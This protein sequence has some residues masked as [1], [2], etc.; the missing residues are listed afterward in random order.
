VLELVHRVAGVEVE[1]APAGPSTADFD[2]C[3]NL[4]Y[5]LGH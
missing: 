1:D 5:E 2:E 4:V 3:R